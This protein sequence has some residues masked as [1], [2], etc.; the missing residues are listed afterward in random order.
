MIDLEKVSI[1]ERFNKDDNNVE[2]SVQISAENEHIIAERFSK[3]HPYTLFTALR[4]LQK[5]LDLDTKDKLHNNV[6]LVEDVEVCNID[7]ADY[8]SDGCEDFL[9]HIPTG[10]LEPLEYKDP[11]F[12]ISA[13]QKLKKNVENSFGSGQFERLVKCTQK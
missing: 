13:I 10:T 5:R 12:T 8:Y 6:F 4:Y 1:V 11:V 2:M 3:D 7:G 9:R